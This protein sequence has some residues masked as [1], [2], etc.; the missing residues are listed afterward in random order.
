MSNV[1]FQRDHH[2]AFGN[3]VIKGI[4]SENMYR[5]NYAGKYM[6]MGSEHTPHG[7]FDSFKNIATRRYIRVKLD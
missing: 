2:K 4:L 3:A 1:P 7:A 6:Y 5:T